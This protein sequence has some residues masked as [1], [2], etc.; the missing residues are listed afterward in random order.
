MEKLTYREYK[1]ALKMI[2]ISYLGNYSQSA[3]MVLNETVGHE[4]TYCLYL[5]PWTLAGTV[6]GRQINTCIGGT[7]CHQFCLS[8][9]GRSKI[10]QL[11]NGIGVSRILQSRIKKTRLFYS[12][13]ELFMAILCYELE[14][15]RKYAYSKG[16]T[17]SVRLNCTSDISP[18]AFKA[19]GMNILEMYP[20]VFFYDYSKVPT[21]LILAARYPNYDI[22]FSYDGFNWDMCEKALN[23]GVNIAVVFESR[24]VPAL[25]KGYHVIDMTKSDLRYKDPK[26][27]NQGFVGFLE[28]HRTA[29]DYKNGKYTRPNTPF[30]VKE[31]DKNIIYAFREQDEPVNVI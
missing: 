25:Y 11:A 10:E 19:N 29:N 7:H 5:A 16:C 24:V 23:M 15:T 31:D 1:N 17:F 30:V 14:H 8:N 20:D 21:R 12:D 6:N 13:R 22:T 18:L 4:I 26:N 3:K 28:Y 9:S 2:G 27:H